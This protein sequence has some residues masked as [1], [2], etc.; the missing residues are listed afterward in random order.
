MKRRRR[1]KV[2]LKAVIRLILGVVL[3]CAGW[4]ASE[5]HRMGQLQRERWRAPLSAESDADNPSRPAPISVAAQRAG[6]HRWVPVS[7]NSDSTGDFDDLF[8]PVPANSYS[9]VAI[10]DLFDPAPNDSTAVR[11]T[12]EVR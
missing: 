11:R 6:S 1:R 5:L 4:F 12:S 10:D 2:R 9:Q 3:F 8:G 7:S